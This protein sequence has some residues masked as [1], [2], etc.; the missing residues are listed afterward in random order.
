VLPKNEDRSHYYAARETDASLLEVSS[1]AKRTENEKFL[2]YRGVG[3]FETPL[4]VK[5]KDGASDTMS[6][7]NKGAEVLPSLFLYEVRADRSIAWT[8]VTALEPG[9]TRVASTVGG[10]ASAEALAAALR[11]SLVRA[12]LYEK[13]AAAMVKTWESSWLQE[14]GMRVLYTLP[15]NWTDRTLPLTLVPAP[16]S[17]VR[18]MLGRAEIIT[19]AME[20]A[21]QANLDRYIHVSPEQRPAIIA[22]TRA[23]DLG[24]FLDPAL[25]RVVQQLKTDDA[26][27]SLI[28]EFISTVTAPEKNANAA[29]RIELERKPFYR[30][31][32]T[33]PAEGVFPFIA[34]TP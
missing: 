24:R 12:G 26:H 32:S 17:A 2:F 3:D 4:I 10:S 18:V 23:L 28:P 33:L 20:Q 29:L 14:R 1:G 21:L 25:V 13:E 15:A 11:S 27:R 6:L 7:E 5:P 19:P 9:E 31:A 8:E 30:D 22:A 34:P 16:K